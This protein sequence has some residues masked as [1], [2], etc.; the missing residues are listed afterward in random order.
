MYFITYLKFYE[1]EFSITSKESKK[2]I[3]YNEIIEKNPLDWLQKEGKDFIL[4][5]YKKIYSDEIENK[6]I[7]EHG[8]YKSIEIEK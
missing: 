2:T 6:D 3:F 5:F 1:P 8:Y 7:I 4:L